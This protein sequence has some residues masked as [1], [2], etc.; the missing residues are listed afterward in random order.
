[1]VET[2]NP[3]EGL[4]AKTLER[5]DARPNVVDGPRGRWLV[6]LGIGAL[7]KRREGAELIQSDCPGDWVRDE[8]GWRPRLVVRCKRLVADYRQGA[9][10]LVVHANDESIGRV[11][12]RN[13]SRIV[14]RL[15]ID[16][17]APVAKDSAKGETTR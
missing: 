9:K 6:G 5:L 17:D 2:V 14:T 8:G 1:M 10:V 15:P 7:G 12:R 3:A 16:A 4:D 11:G 13:R